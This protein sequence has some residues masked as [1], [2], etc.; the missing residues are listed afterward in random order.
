VVIDSLIILMGGLDDIFSEFFA[1]LFL[2]LAQVARAE[3]LGAVDVAVDLFRL[4]SPWKILL[5]SNALTTHF[6]INRTGSTDLLEHVPF[7]VLISRLE[8]TE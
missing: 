3:E 8:L 1:G 2:F 6:F 7:P 5:T 4:P